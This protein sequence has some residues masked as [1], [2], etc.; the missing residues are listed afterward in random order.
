[1]GKKGAE[2]S[3][4]GASRA[5]AKPLKGWVRWDKKKEDWRDEEKMKTLET[6]MVS[7]TFESDVS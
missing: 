1:M 7:S 2:G 3:P 5:N 4:T 6:E